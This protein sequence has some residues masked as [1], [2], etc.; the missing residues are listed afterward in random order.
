MW[1]IYVI[2]VILAVFAVWGFLSLVGVETR[3]LSRKT[4]RRAEDLYDRFAA[5]R[6]KRHRR[7]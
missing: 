4:S 5:P 2:V 1:W 6:A 3:W 7:S